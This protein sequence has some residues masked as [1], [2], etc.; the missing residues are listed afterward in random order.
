MCH[1]KM[2]LPAVAVMVAAIWTLPTA[3][4]VA[5]IAGDEV[6][7]TPT[8]APPQ[9]GGRVTVEWAGLSMLFPDTWTVDV[10]RAPGVTVAG[11]SILVAFG[12]DE[13]GCL[14]DRFDSASVESWQD[15]GVEPVVELTI[16]GIRV[17]RFDDMLGT[18]AVTVSAYTIH[19][20]DHQYSLLCSSPEP[21][22]DRWLSLVETIE[23]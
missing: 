6:S 15:V 13:S 16:S 14:L 20:P 19:A 8:P 7:P 1:R 17:E 3:S 4:P 2:S 23:L 18:G 11:A 5:A 10:K 21:P 12:P 9:V 22:G